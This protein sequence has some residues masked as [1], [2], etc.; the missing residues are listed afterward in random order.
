VAALLETSEK[1]KQMANNNLMLKVKPQQNTGAGTPLKKMAQPTPQEEIERLQTSLYSANIIIAELR[2][3]LYEAQTANDSVRRELNEEKQ[4]HE[5]SSY[6][7]LASNLRRTEERLW[8]AEDHAHAM[9]K[10][11]MNVLDAMTKELTTLRNSSSLHG[12]AVDE[13]YAR[14]EEGRRVIEDPSGIRNTRKLFSK[15]NEI[16][17]AYQNLTAP[18]SIKL[19]GAS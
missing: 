11:S 18:K 14:I 9:I 10:N 15:L 4:K 13:L 2:K 19:S 16:V 7:L 8:E 12:K 1:D 17:V 3:E 5:Q 6:E